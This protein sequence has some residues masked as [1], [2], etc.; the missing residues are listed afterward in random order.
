M[1]G[2][3]A[4]ILPWL[5][6]TPAEQLMPDYTSTA[7]MLV[8]LRTTPAALQYACQGKGHAE[9]AARPAEGEWSAGEVLC[10]LRDVERE[11]F[12][13]RVQKVTQ[14]DNPFLSGRDTDRWAEERRYSE[15]DGLRALEDF[16]QTRLV[17]L[18]LLEG[19]KPEDWSLGARHAI[20]GPTRLH[21]L[22]NINAGH[23]RLH[24]RQV[25]RA[26]SL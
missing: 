4:D 16:T 26:L 25:Y 17:Q 8:I 21:E 11:V 12:L 23:D 2:K 13:P 1:Q 24:I 10:H 20:F 7:A 19:L 22:V 6:S 5:D 15:Q 14:E 3:L 9:L 18:A